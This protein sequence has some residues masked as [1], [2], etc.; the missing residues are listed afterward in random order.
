MKLSP[1]ILAK[2]IAIFASTAFIVATIL[3]QLGIVEVANLSNLTATT[4]FAS[5][6]TIVIVFR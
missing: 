3:G 6:M 4:L 5:I 2:Y 1:Q